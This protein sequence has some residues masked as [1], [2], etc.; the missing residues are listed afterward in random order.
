LEGGGLGQ[1][2]SEAAE[3]THKFRAIDRDS[4]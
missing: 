3:E 2:F 4:N 1:N